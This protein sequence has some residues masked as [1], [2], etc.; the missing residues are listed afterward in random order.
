MRVSGSKHRA[1]MLGG[2]AG[3][4]ALI[5]AGLL[6]LGALTGHA[7]AA[8]GAPKPPAGVGPAHETFADNDPPSDS[9][10]DA[11]AL[12]AAVAPG[13]TAPQVAWSDSG[14]RTLGDW[15]GE[16]LAAVQRVAA[17]YEPR[18]QVQVRPRGGGGSEAQV[19]L[20][21]GEPDV[22]TRM[23]DGAGRLGVT[24]ATAKTKRRGHFFLFAAARSDA[25]G[26][27]LLRGPEGELRRAGWS[28]EKIAVSGDSQIGAGW[29][30]GPL[31]AS[32]GF[33]ERQFS[34]WGHSAHERYF[35]F[36]LSFRP[37]RMGSKSPAQASREREERFRER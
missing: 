26:F 10:G 17:L 13:R 11:E 36:T 4:T 23:S 20:A 31:Q 25:V 24:Q 1:A 30:K 5:T 14:D 16:R 37:Q 27:N 3:L 28:A 29:R 33:V 12:A 32:F 34:S 7:G 19:Q 2:V 21:F 15:G 6:I 35:G 9:G 8:I 18:L 22:R